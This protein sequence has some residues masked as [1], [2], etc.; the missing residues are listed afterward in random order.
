MTLLA[1]ADGRVCYRKQTKTKTISIL[2]LFRCVILCYYVK[3]SY[4]SR[5][6]T[7]SRRTQCQYSSLLHTSTHTHTHTSQH[8]SHSLCLGAR[9][10][11]LRFHMKCKMTFDVM[12]PP[13]KQTKHSHGCHESTM[14]F[15]WVATGE[16]E[17]EEK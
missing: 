6:Y 12:E 16:E 5:A 14:A 11:H 3:L 13:P 17:E 1:H 9:R 8:V 15:S 7:I 4:Y 10:N 2:L